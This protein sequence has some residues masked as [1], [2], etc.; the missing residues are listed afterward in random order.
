ME[1]ILHLIQKL[2]KVEEAEAKCAQPVLL[3]VAEVVVVWEIR[4]VKQ[5]VEQIKIYMELEM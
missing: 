1:E 2:Q 3:V 5:V 4:V